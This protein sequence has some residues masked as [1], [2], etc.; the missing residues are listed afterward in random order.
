VVLVRLVEAEKQIPL[1]PP[2][3]KGEAEAAIWFLPEALNTSPL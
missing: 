2:F 3:S 1:N